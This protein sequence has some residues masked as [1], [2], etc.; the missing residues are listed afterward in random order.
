MTKR[1]ALR[2]HV[3][4]VVTTVFALLPMTA[5]AFQILPRISDVDRK[6]TSLGG[7]QFVDGVGQW[8]VG[9]AL[10]MIKSPVH[11]VITLSA[12]GC[13]TDPGSEELCLNVDAVRENQVLLYGVRWPDDPPFA[14]NRAAP[15]RVA[16]CDPKIT[17]RSTAQPKCWKGLFSDADKTA[18]QRIG[19]R[20]GQPAFGPGE[21]LLYRS[22][23]GDLQFF[24]A[25]AAYEGEPA[26]ETLQRMK[27]GARFLWGIAT[28][29]TRTDQFIRESSGADMQ[30]Y[31]PGDITPTNLFATGIV[32]VR[33]DLDK[34]ALGALLHMVQDS[35]SQAHANRSVESGAACDKIPRFLRPATVGQ[36]YNYSGQS[37]SLHDGEDAFN[38]LRLHTIQVSPS[39]IDATKAFLTLWD[40]KATWAEAEK[41]FDCAL[42]IEADAL[43]AS[44]GPFAN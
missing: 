16:G 3:Y 29:T 10:P 32:E 14:L 13:S 15:P 28:K 18:R 25:M 27:M 26:S 33:K 23:F 20:P 17:L 39:V 40:E 12:L 1:C 22:H 2:C 35:F 43:P 7:N 31:F 24:H 42:A 11:E 21:Y 36:F 41:Y 9:N 44:A 19:T 34:V 5:S 38:T 30:R 4:T 8:F 37:A 6:L